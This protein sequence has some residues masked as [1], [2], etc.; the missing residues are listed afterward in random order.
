MDTRSLIHEFARRYTAAWCSQ[1]P[2][3]VASHFAV[4]GSLRVNEGEVAIGRDAI[5]AL[6]HGFMA[7]FPNLIVRMDELLFEPNG[8]IYRWT[9]DGTTNGRRVI[10]S[11]YEEWELSADGLIAESLGHFDAADYQRQVDGGPP[12]PLFLDE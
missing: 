5:S 4:G 3:L 8:I 7:A 9:L 1:D 6:A 11:G 12:L 2:A 10:I